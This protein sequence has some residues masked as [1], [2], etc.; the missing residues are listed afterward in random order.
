MGVKS[1]YIVNSWRVEKSYWDSPKLDEEYLWRHLLLGLEQG[2]D[3]TLPSIQ[4]RR[5]LR[6]FVEEELPG[7]VGE[8]MTLVAH[9][10][11]GRECPRAVAGPLTLAVGPEGGFI[12]EE[13]EMFE[14]AGFCPVRCGERI[15][16][17][18]YAVPALLGRLF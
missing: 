10:G 16:R 5:F 18:E 6:P 1:V 13:I 9:P 14:R 17:V 3:T 4:T 15:L 2:R 8:S 12:D 11:A 7:L